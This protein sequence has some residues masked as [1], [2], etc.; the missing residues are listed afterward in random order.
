MNAKTFEFE[1]KGYKFLGM[2]LNVIDQAKMLKRV[3]PL[4][5]PLVPL[6]VSLE[7]GD[8]FNLDVAKIMKMAEPLTEALNTLKDDDFT[9]LLQTSAASVKVMID[10]K[11]QVFWSR[12]AQQGQFDDLSDLSFVVPITVRCIQ[13][14]LS[15]FFSDA[16]TNLPRPM[17]KTPA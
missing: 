6:L 10:E 3:M 7:E 1:V 17:T 8:A 4:I 12:G 5:P 14:N 15:S 2:R 16:V 13:E 11:W 9:W